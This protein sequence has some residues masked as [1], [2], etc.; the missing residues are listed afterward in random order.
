MLKG[1]SPIVKGINPIVCDPK[2]RITVPLR[3]RSIV[4][5]NFHNRVLITAYPDG[6][7]RVYPV[8]LWG[9]IEKALNNLPAFHQKWV[10]LR[11]LM[12]GCATEC[13]VDNQSRVPLPGPLVEYVGEDR[14]WILIGMGS[15]LEIW[16]Y[17][18]WLKKAKDQ[19]HGS[20]LLKFMNINAHQVFGPSSVC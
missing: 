6:C 4:K 20:R 8:D 18:A 9:E 12:L 11:R 19:E 10:D 13:E 7:L 15:W 17:S 16:S 2:G 1:I 3:Y 14:K 5:E